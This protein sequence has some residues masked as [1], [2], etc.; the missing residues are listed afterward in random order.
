SKPTIHNT[1]YRDTSSIPSSGVTKRIAVP[2]NP[3][4]RLVVL[5]LKVI[6]EQK[7]NISA[8]T[9]YRGCSGKAANK[10]F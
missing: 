7:E 2:L 8:T 5:A 1:I 4:N 6:R 10:T 3:R 9:K